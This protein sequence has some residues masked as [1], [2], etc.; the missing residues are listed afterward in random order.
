MSAA[1]RAALS[2][3]RRGGGGG[4][5][6]G[7]HRS[8]P[9]CPRRRRFS[10]GQ[11]RRPRPRLGP[12]PPRSR[13]PR[14]RRPAR[15]QPHLPA[16][17]LPGAAC[18][19]HL[20]TCLTRGRRAHPCPACPW[21]PWRPGGRP[22]PAAAGGTRAVNPHA[23]LGMERPIPSLLGRPTRCPRACGAGGH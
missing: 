8:S 14:P 16:R 23:W 22:A 13:R 6:S 4:T 1:G 10:T 21:G 18:S 12:A 17:G 2:P 5:D 9:R 11:R 20:H 7:E 3:W 15:G 19:F